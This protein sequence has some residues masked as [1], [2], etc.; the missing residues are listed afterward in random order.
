MILDTTPSSAYL[1]QGANV[2]DAGRQLYAVLAQ[3]CDGEALDLIQNVT[4]SD[5][6]EAYRVLSRRFDPPGCREEA[7]HHAAVAAAGFL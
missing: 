4:G 1:Q 7:Q 6:C 2:K 5:G 3:L